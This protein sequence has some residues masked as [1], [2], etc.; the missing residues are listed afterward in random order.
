[1]YHIYGFTRV[2]KEAKISRACHGGMPRK[3][4]TSL[5]AIF[6]ALPH[7][8]YYRE[9]FSIQFILRVQNPNL[10]NVDAAVLQT[11]KHVD[12]LSFHEEIL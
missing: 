5:K 12:Y 6:T 1:M 10:A 7:V 3:L 8:A 2:P 11:F 9:I 4:L